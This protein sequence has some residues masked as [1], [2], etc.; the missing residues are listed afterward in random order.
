MQLLALTAMEPPIAMNADDVRWEKVKVLHALRGI[1]PEHVDEFAVRGQ[2]AAGVIG[3]APVPAY[4]A[5]PNVAPASTTE[6]FV[7]LKLYVDNWRWADVPFYVR[8]G[9]RLPK[10]VT[11]IAIQFKRPP[12]LLFAKDA[13]TDLAPNLLALR[14]QPDEGITLKFGSKVP[15][16]VINIRS[17][18]MDFRYGTA[19]GQEPP[20]AYERLIFDALLG[21]AT[22]FTRSDEVEAAWRFITPILR[23]WQ[24][25]VGKD[26][27]LYEAGTWGPD[28]AHAFIE[29]DGR[30]WRKL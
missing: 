4:R 24:R 11:E 14:I 26:F 25:C 5:E 27:L 13:V 9:K 20:E 22:L 12:L 19:F 15:G 30:C 23:G 28:A 16:Q 6:T 17:V 29:R 21:D 8:T 1:D 18:N 3:G 10:R 7:A 2:Y